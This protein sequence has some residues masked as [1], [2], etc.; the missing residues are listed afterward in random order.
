MYASKGLVFGASPRP[1]NSLYFLLNKFS[2]N[3]LSAFPA[4]SGFKPQKK[5]QKSSQQNRCQIMNALFTTHH[6]SGS[7]NVLIFLYTMGIAQLSRRRFTWAVTPVRAHVA[8]P[9]AW[10]HDV[11]NTLVLWV[12]DEP[13]SV[14]I[15]WGLHAERIYK[16]QSKP[17]R[18]R[19]VSFY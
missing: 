3:G 8:A 19:R 15:K 1:L 18:C 13:M 7:T 10:S 14:C 17:A 11:R 9:G 2:P 12:R 5:S 16:L 6:M 4:Y